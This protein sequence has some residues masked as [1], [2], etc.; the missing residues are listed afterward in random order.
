[1][2]VYIQQSTTSFHQK[3]FFD[4]FLI[5]EIDTE[6][7][8]I[9]SIKADKHKLTVIFDKNI[10]LSEVNLS[11]N[12]LLIPQHSQI[13]NTIIESKTLTLEYETEF[14]T[15]DYYFTALK[16]KDAFGNFNPT[17][18]S[19]NYSYTKPY[20][21][22]PN[23]IVINEI[24]AD[25]SP[26]VDLPTSEFIELYNTTNERI[27]LKG[28]KYSDATSTYTFGDEYILP[29][30]FLILCSKNDTTEYKKYG[31]VTGIS[32]WPSLNNDKDVPTLSNEKGI[33]IHR[34][35]YFDTWYKEPVMK[36]G[37]YS[38]ELIDPASSCIQSQDV[39]A[40]IDPGR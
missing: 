13:V 3:H 8:E 27:A 21:A 26:Q 33:I 17:P 1:F 30:E 7:P 19:I 15:G 35:A 2:G 9:L 24:F 5:K 14:E 25:P 12:F 11:G 4:N 40:S 16:I 20:A 22:K 36:N 23:D 31:R 29:H 34:D 37:G 6:A 18:L 10:D 28:F 39:M 32:P 38:L